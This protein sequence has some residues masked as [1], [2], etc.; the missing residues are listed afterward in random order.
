MCLASSSYSRLNFDFWFEIGREEG[1]LDPEER[2]DIN[3]EGFLYDVLF[4][5]PG[6]RPWW[7]RGVG[8]HSI[9]QAMAYAEQ[10][11]RDRVEWDV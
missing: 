2:P 1:D 6:D 11:L 4:S 9:D 5:D 3:T 7:V 8:W 10:E